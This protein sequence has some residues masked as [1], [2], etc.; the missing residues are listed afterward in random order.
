MKMFLIDKEVWDTISKP[1]P[2]QPNEE[3]LKEDVKA[4][5]RIGLMAEDNQLCHRRKE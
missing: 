1:R 3:W 4:L 2:A 5:A